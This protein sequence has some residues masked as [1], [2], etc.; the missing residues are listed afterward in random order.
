MKIP[1]L[2]RREIREIAWDVHGQRATTHVAG[3]DPACEISGVS[4]I[5][6]H[7]ADDFGESVIHV[8]FWYLT[9]KRCNSSH[10]EMNR[11]ERQCSSRE[12]AFYVNFILF[13]ILKLANSISIF[14]KIHF[15]NSFFDKKRLTKDVVLSKAMRENQ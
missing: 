3:Y 5:P 13:F 12:N 15:F 4:K 1:V 7:G 10:A 6:L 8:I 14:Q 2:I 9:L 11:I